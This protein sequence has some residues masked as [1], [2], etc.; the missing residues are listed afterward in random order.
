MALSIRIYSLRYGFTQHFS[1]PAGKAY[2]WCTDYQPHDLA[3]MRIGGER[4]IRK[5]TDDAILLDE[6][7]YSKGH[8]VKKTKLVRLDRSRLSWSSTHV[9]GPNLHSQFL[10]RIVPVGKG[11]SKLNFNGLLILYSKASL[12]PEKTSQI[13]KDERRQDSRSW[14]HLANT[15]AQELQ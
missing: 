11:S 4:R 1:V 8:A 14:R 5:I 7:T 10:Y 6:T 15:M 12:S 13:A 2:D 9:S 3:L